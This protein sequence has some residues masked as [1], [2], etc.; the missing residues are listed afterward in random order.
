VKLRLA[1]KSI[2]LHWQP[3]L[4]ATTIP[5]V[6]LN[7]DIMM[8]SRVEY[9]I[10]STPLVLVIYIPCFHWLSATSDSSILCFVA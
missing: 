1:A 8:Q 3:L 9:I 6:V 5:G 2:F 4:V 10:D 7:P